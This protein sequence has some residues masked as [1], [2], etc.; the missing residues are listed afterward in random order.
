MQFY[1]LTQCIRYAILVSGCKARWR[2][3]METTIINFKTDNSL[4]ITGTYKHIVAKTIVNQQ[5]ANET[6]AGGKYENM[7][8]ENVVFEN[9]TIQAS[10]FLETKFIDCKFKNCNFSSTKFVSCN[11]VACTFENCHFCITNSLTCNFLSC[12]FLGNTWKLGVTRDN[13]LVNCQVHDETYFRME[14][15]GENNNL[16]SCFENAPLLDQVAA[17]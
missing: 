3:A 9:C 16:L 12:T 14:A 11:L 7:V 6:L 13:K 2:L 5:I 17:A 1:F 10:V 4:E 8:F 15:E